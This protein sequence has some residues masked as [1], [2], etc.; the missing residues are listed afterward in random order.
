MLYSAIFAR[1]ARAVC[2][3]RQAATAHL[4]GASRE[5]CETLGLRVHTI[6][7]KLRF[8][9]ANLVERKAEVTRRI[10]YRWTQVREATTIAL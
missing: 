8:I 5:P 2:S 9:C 10:S 6:Q 3:V 4:R 7:C 1:L